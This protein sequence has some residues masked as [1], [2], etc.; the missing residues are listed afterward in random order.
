[1][2]KVQL[3]YMNISDLS[4]SW[5]TCISKLRLQRLNSSC[6]EL[7]KKQSMGV[8]L[9]LNYYALKN[10]KPTP[11]EYAYNDLG[12]PYVSD[13]SF[14]FSL[15]HS[16][17]I[18]MCAVSE[19]DVGLDVETKKEVRL[20][21][22]NKVLSKSEL[23]RFE[24]AKNKIDFII[25][26]FTAKEAYL[27]LTGQGLRFPMKNLCVDGSWIVDNQNTKIAFVTT[28]KLMNA[29]FAVATQ[30]EH[31]IELYPVT[32]EDIVETFPRNIPQN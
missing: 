6:Q 32:I 17:N 7:Q 2:Q 25:E 18:A 22:S 31:K 19:F 30:N 26:I 12:K 16:G 5:H 1:M 14:Y 21:L 20:E 27:K 23:K 15:A 11:V 13:N 29:R 3:F 24:L 4:L 8:E 28:Q 10:S 9:L